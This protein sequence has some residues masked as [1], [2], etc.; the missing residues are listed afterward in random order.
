MTIPTI[1]ELY[2]SIIENFKSEFG[3]NS[4]FIGKLFIRALSAVQAAKLYLLYLALA[5][6]QKN[7]FIDTADPESA[8]GTLERFGRVKLGRDPFDAEQG[9]YSVTTTGEVGATIPAGKTY[10]SNDDSLNPGKIF[11]LDNAFTFTSTTETVTLRALEAGTG[12]QLNIGD[13]LT[14]TSPIV[15]VQTGVTVLSEVSAPIDAENIEVYRDLGKQAFRLEPQGGSPGDYRIW[16]SDANGVVAVYPYAD[17]ATANSARIFVEGNTPDGT[18]PASVLTEVEA[19]ILQDPDTTKPANE[20]ARRP[21]GVLNVYVVPVTL[22]VVD[23]EITGLSNDTPAIRASIEAA[24]AEE[25]KKIRP[26]IA[27]AEVLSDQNDRLTTGKIITVVQGVIGTNEFFTNLTFQV[28]S[29][30]VVSSYLFDNGQIPNLG[31]IDF[32]L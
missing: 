7:I 32:I 28:N 16:A 31:T 24:I 10:K 14:E 23:I 15:N 2:N 6:V 3:V 5:E 13:K 11:I 20:R 27:A 21:Q 17:G 30:G 12:S 9:E 8:G 26:F 22:G 19:V 1:N 29:G 25:L 18:P 4:N